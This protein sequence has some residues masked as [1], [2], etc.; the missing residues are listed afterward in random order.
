MQTSHKPAAKPDTPTPGLSPTRLVQSIFSQQIRVRRSDNGFKLVLEG[1][2]GA[3][4][5]VEATK[6]QEALQAKLMCERL[7]ALLDSVADS[8]RVLRHLAGVE[9]GLKH[10]E[11][12]AL[13]LFDVPP[14]RLKVALRQLDG[15]LGE[16]VPPELGALRLR[17]SDAIEVQEALER[18][19]E[20][21][22]PISS[23]F[24]DHKIE[25]SE[26]RAS[27]FENA[28]AAWEGTPPGASER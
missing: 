14:E 28:R 23:F 1:P 6:A 22:Q 8:R 15:L 18:Q 2:Q 17:L 21:R 12:G 19:T 7:G 16:P 3:A 10:K 5:V 13:F 24:V 11:A 25:V 26:A 4:E 9:H 27:D 20:L